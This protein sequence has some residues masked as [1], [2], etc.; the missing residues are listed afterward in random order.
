MARV[1]DLYKDRI[2]PVSTEVAEVWGRFNAIESLPVID[3]L[4]AAT[5]HVYGLVV[6]TR[7]VKDIARTGVPVLDPFNTI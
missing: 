6:V 3:S 1:L 5:A 2:L 4:I 7:N